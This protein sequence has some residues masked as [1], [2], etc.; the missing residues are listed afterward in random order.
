MKKMILT[1]SLMSMLFFVGS[2]LA[3]DEHHPEKKDAPATSQVNTDQMQLDQMDSQTKMMEEVRK[4]VA[5]EKDPKAREALMHEHMQMM[6]GDMNMMGMMGGKGMMGG[7]SGMSMD[8]RMD[9]MEKKI[10]MMQG[11]MGGKGMMCGPSDMAMDARMSMM[12]KKINMMQEIMQGMMLQ[13]E[14]KTK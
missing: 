11:M 7:G 13:Q 10:N 12:E 14:M 5:T 1:A 8:D 6:K 4:K 3:V 2:A 9:M